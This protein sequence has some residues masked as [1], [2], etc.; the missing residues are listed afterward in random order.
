[1][2]VL[3]IS[4]SQ[5]GQLAK[6]VDRFLQGLADAKCTHVQ[7]RPKVPYPFPWGGLV[8]FFGAMPGIVLEKPV[9]LE[10]VNQ[11]LLAEHYDL[12]VIGYQPWFLRIPPPLATFLKQSGPLFLSSRTVVTIGASRDMWFMAQ[13]Q[14]DQ[15]I[16]NSGGHIRR[17]LVVTDK[18]PNLLS[19]ITTPAWLVFGQ[20]KL[21]PLPEAGIR[22]LQLHKLFDAAKHMHMKGLELP[23]DLSL[24]I[25]AENL[26]N[27]RNTVVEPNALKLFRFSAIWM[28]HPACQGTITRAFA[29]IIFVCYFVALLPI[30]LSLQVLAAVRP[31][32]VALTSF[33][34]AGADKGW[35]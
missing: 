13:N 24:E 26:L 31:S 8:K 2:K 33:V 27:S 16:A 12:V 14:L 20:K 32:R 28:S 35:K 22:S 3:A 21:G 29:V 6:C 5:S 11:R 1:V 9:E 7:I 17:R 23:E 10:P 4:F 18:T 25:D 34:Q 15:L 19:L 30:L